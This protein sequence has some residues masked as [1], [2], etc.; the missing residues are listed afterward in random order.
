MDSYNTTWI[1][2]V[3]G[4]G[5]TWTFSIVKE[6]LSRQSLNV[7]PTTVYK[8]KGDYF[9]VYK[10]NA[11]SDRNSDNH[12]VLQCHAALALYLIK[13]RCKVITNVRNPYDNCAS[14]YEFMKCDLEQAISNAKHI[15]LLVNH[16]SK[17]DK[18]QMFLLKYEDIDEKPVDLIKRIAGFLGFSLDEV[19]AQ[20]LADKYSRDN[21][22]RMIA[23]NERAL[24]E[25][26]VTGKHVS[27][28]E[29]VMTTGIDRI[30]SFDTETG[31]QSHHISKRKT[32][33]WRSAFSQTEIPRII[34]SLA[35]TAKR[36]GYK[37][38][39]I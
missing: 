33:E 23:N 16:Y 22:R 38:E 12:Y 2:T 35:E 20:T 29:V 11:L 7:L 15:P 5:T 19:V 32:G 10:E 9:R 25:K 13:S 8:A 31:Y 28:D 34:G 4:T 17:L 26:L 18:E 27:S 3:T 39:S 21:V 30:G 1:A 14:H 24:H 36:L 6:I 37:A